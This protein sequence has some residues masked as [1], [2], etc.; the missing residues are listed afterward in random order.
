MTLERRGSF[1]DMIESPLPAPPAARPL[2]RALEH[3]QAL[4]GPA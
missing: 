3:V 2:D 1:W 4:R